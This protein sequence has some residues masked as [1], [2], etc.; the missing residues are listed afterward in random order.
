[1]QRVRQLRHDDRHR[2]VLRAVVDQVLVDLVGD[3]PDPALDGP[4]ADRLDLLRRVDR[5][6][7]VGR[8]VEQQHLGA[9]GGGG[10]ELLDR[11][12]V[13][14]RLVGDH[15]HR[16]AAGERDRLRVGGPVRRRAAAPRHRG[17]AAWRTPGRRPACRRWSPAPGRRRP[18]SPSHAG[19][20]RRPLR[21]APA[22][23][24]SGCSGGCRVGASGD[25]G[26]DDRVGGG[27]VRF[28]GAEADHRPAG[29]LEGL[30]LRVDGQRGRFG[31]A[32]DAG[33]SGRSAAGSR[34]LRWSARC[35]RSDDA[36]HVLTQTHPARAP[37]PARPASGPARRRRA[38][39][40]QAPRVPYTWR[41]GCA[42]PACVRA[43]GHILV[44]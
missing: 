36:W 37:G 35:H 44:P 41:P 32:A 16:H 20:S 39:S 10:L 42:K 19:S 18:R 30:R 13:A 9:V 33:E 7:G 26:L 4:P 24:A 6:G 21:A 38:S 3:H 22:G 17:R 12:Q 28:A 31:D 8:R 23:R 34:R 27:E 5:A 14:G 11:D 15:R 25:R 29:G 40:R 2:D 43:G 1:M